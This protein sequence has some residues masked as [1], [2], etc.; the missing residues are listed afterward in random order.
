M[1]VFVRQLSQ[2]ANSGMQHASAPPHWL[3]HLGALGIFSVAVI[4]SSVIPLSIPGSTDLLL[5]WL[6]AHGGDSWV[7]AASAIAGSLLGGYTTWQAGRKG[8][9]SAL[10]HYV[11]A[12]LLG[13]IVGWVERHPVLA[14][15]LPAV[16][17]PPI[18]LFPF[19]LAA[20]ALGV[21][22][23]RFLLVYGAARS[24]RYSIIGWVAVLYGRK[25]VRMW[26]GS[27]E[28]WSALL[29]WSFAGL[30]VVGAC[31]GIWKLRRLRRAEVAEGIALSPKA[32]CGG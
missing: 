7:L 26:S 3:T 27:I 13:R 22:R 21:S 24:L 2:I 4:D 5:L 31:F 11:P 32:A 14:V 28:R 23:N 12:R 25:V 20:G 1:S 9:E 8:G 15:F 18:P 30:L 29:L 10:R 6:I 17:P 19:V 16:L